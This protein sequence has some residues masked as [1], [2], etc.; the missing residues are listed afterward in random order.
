[1][2]S[3]KGPLPTN[4]IFRKAFRL[5]IVGAEQNEPDEKEKHVALHQVGDAGELLGQGRKGRRRVTLRLGARALAQ[6][7]CLLG[8]G[9]ALFGVVVEE[10]V[11]LGVELRTK[12]VDAFA[13]GS[14]AGTVEK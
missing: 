12:L 2:R 9:L 1:M 11:V 13:A 3:R 4:L 6:P 14:E 7:L 8:L 5:E 10:N